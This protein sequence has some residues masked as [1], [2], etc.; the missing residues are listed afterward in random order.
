[1]TEANGPSAFR[2]FLLRVRGWFTSLTSR[3]R[4]LRT[5]P[6]RLAASLRGRNGAIAGGVGAAVLGAVVFMA[7]PR[8][9]EAQVERLAVSGQ[10]LYA[11]LLQQHPGVAR[12]SR[13]D[14]GEA[15][16]SGTNLI[17]VPKTAWDALSVAQRNSLGTWLNAVGGRWE[18]RVGEGSKD[19][20]R[21]I[22]AQPVVTSREWNQHLR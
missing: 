16:G 11:E 3:L 15:R 1:M 19:G 17:V 6:A 22:D 21:V 9:P 10:A 5:L 14:E 4:Q 7:I 13:V 8:G 12:S 18:I 20:E 2:A